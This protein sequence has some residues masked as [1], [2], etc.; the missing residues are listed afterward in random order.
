[1]DANASLSPPMREYSS[2]SSAA[3]DSPFVA[4]VAGFA[5]SCASSCPYR[6]FS[7]PITASFAK[8]P[9]KMDTLA[10][11]LSFSTPMGSK[12]GVMLRPTTER[13]DFSL[14][15][16]P[17]DPSVPIVLRTPSA[18]TIGT[19]NLP[20]RQMKI[21]SR[22]HVWRRMCLGRGMW[23]GGN[24]MMKCVGEPWKS[25]CFMRSPV[26]MPRTIPHK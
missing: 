14:S 10:C 2:F 13:T 6:P 23:Y 16:L 15:S 25:V 9:V 12:T 11:Q 1:M 22:S 18:S 20:A 3:A 17:I 26:T 7:V 21:F 24:S 8:R 19:M 4:L 5:A